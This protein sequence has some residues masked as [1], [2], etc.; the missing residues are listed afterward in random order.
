MG[1]HTHEQRK[2]SLINSQGWRSETLPTLKFIT[3]QGQQPAYEQGSVANKGQV[4]L[5]TR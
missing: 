1:P 2:H 5:G 4:S 3:G